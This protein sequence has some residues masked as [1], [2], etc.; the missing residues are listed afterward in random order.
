MPTV[1]ESMS[2]FPLIALDN[3]ECSFYVRKSRLSLKQV[4]VLRGFTLNIY[5]GET[6]GVIGHNGAGKSTLLQILGRILEPTG[7][8][9]H[10]RD[11]LS[12]SLLTLQLGF[13]Q[14]LTGR[15]NAVLGAMFLGFARKEAESRLARILDFA[16]IGE[17][18]DEPIRTYSTGMKARLGFAVAMEME[19]NIM[20]IDETLGVG[21]AY[22]QHKSN[23]SL[24]E[25]M[26]SGQ[27][28]V[29][30]AH[31]DGVLRTLCSRVVWVREGRVHMEGAPDV[32]LDAYNTWVAQLGA[33]IAGVQ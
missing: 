21:D 5:E 30:V 14:E 27:T 17:W 13:A 22:F 24:V 33:G 32:V 1:G 15:E 4:D 9:V 26:Q 7:G 10:F 20:L 11:N 3:V 8:E 18:A 6:L 16:E 29:L 28:T 12:I 23:Q 19:P 2:D 31:S 25:K